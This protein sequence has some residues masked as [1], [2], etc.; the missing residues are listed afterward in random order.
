MGDVLYC[1]PSEMIIP[2]GTL[3]VTSGTADSG[4][5]VVNLQD[6]NPSKPF[7]ATGNAVTIRATY[8]GAVTAKMVSLGPHNLV[9]A[10]VSL[11]NNAGTPLNQSITI[12]ANSLNGLSVDPF[13]D[14]SAQSSSL[15]ATQWNLVITGAAANVAIGEWH[16]AAEKRVLK[17]QMNPAQEDGVA[18]G[19]T[20]HP[21]SMGGKLKSN[22][23]WAVRRLKGRVVVNANTVAQTL[24]IL[25]AL[26]E[27]ARGQFGQFLLVPDSAV[28]DALYVDLN[29][30]EQ[31]VVWLT[32]LRDVGYIDIEFVQVQ[33]GPRL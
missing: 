22:R 28:N 19:N 21:T 9:G 3:S 7:K 12:P 18:H 13:V 27:D 8:G 10:T 14:F 2:N 31:V 32:T 16:L 1:R 20:I 5:P 24:A 6:R 25:R 26:A 4:Y 33:R 30:D 17:I 23:G 29:S 11:T 15:S